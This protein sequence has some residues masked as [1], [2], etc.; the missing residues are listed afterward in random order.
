[1]IWVIQVLK[2]NLKQNKIFKIRNPK[3][4]NTGDYTE[5]NELKDRLEEVS[6]VKQRQK[7]R[8]HRRE[9]TEGTIK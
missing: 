3:I 2:K 1:M 9:E 7:E 4:R 8:T 5:S 6:Q